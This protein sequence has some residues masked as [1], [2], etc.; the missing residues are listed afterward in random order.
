[1]ELSKLVGAAVSG[2]GTVGQDNLETGAQVLEL[3][4]VGTRDTEANRVGSSIV[5]VLSD[6]VDGGLM[7][8]LGTGRV[9]F[10]EAIPG[11]RATG[12]CIVERVDVNEAVSGTGKQRG[13]VKARR[14]GRGNE[15]EDSSDD[16]HYDFV[17][18]ELEEIWHWK[19]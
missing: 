3:G 4:V 1:M 15:R 8:A 18:R 9:L 2:Q 17:E 16:L 12:V 6:N 11:Q 14:G 7:L 19:R 13:A 5:N 10:T